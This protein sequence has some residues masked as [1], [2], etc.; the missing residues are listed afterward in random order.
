[1]MARYMYD[2]GRGN[3]DC[4]D[5]MA[6]VAVKNHHHA[7]PNENAQF[8][9]EFTVDAIKNSSMVAHPVRLLHCSPVTDGASALILTTPEKANLR[10]DNQASGG[11]RHEGSQRDLR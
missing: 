1:M 3:E 11:S 5:A 2:Y 4:G 9:R 10:Q 6:M 8:R 7:M